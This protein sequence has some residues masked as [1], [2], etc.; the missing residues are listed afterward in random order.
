M[1]GT[2]LALMLLAAAAGESAWPAEAPRIQLAQVMI[3]ERVIIRVPA[4]AAPPKIRWREKKGPKCMPMQSVAGAAILKAGRVDL[5]VRGGQRMRAELES[6][7]TALDYYS[8]FYIMPPTDGQI[9]AGRDTI[10]LRSGGE[11]QIKR[12]RKLV[13]DR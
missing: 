9:C 12:F 5:I 6:G 7:C 2:G 3:R 4:A 13:P 8:G 1:I 11:C 10:H